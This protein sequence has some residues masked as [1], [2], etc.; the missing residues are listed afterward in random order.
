[1]NE[2]PDFC[3]SCPIRNVTEGYAPLTH[4]TGSELLVGEASGEEEVVQGRQFVGGAGSWL[5]SMLRAARLSRGKF[6]IINTI[7]CRPPK[8]C[9][10]TDENFE[11]TSRQYLVEKLAAER[12]I[13][14]HKQP[15]TRA[16]LEDEIAPRVPTRADGRAAVEYCARHH[17]LPVIDELEP[18]RIVAL[19]DHALR[20]LTPRQGVLT[21]RGSPLPLKGRIAEGLRV[22]GTLHPAYLMRNAGLF[23]VAVQDLRRSLTIAPEH[24]NLWP[25]LEDVRKFTATEFSFDFEWDDSGN[26][27]ICGLSDRYYHALVVPWMEPYLGELRRIFE[28]AT[29]FIGQNIIGA[30][31]QHFDRL[32]WNFQRLGWKIN[33]RVIDIMLIQHLVQPDMRHD[34]GFIGSVFANKVYW[35]G[36]GEE[37]EDE[38]G[39][40]AATG[41]QWK[42]WDS[43]DAIPREFG[44]YGGCAN[45]A[46]SFRLYNARDTEGSLQC[47]EPLLASLKKFGLEHT[48]WNVSV[49]AAH[50][51]RRMAEHG[52]RVNNAKVVDIRSTIVEQIEKIEKTLPEGLAPY[53]KAIIRQIEAP[54]DTYKPKSR[55][56]KGS[57]K[58][59]GRHEPREFVFTRPG[60]SVTC[61]ECSSELS[62]PKLQ[63]LKRIK[64]PGTER[65]TPWNSAEQVKKYAESLGCKPYLHSKT[66]RSTADKNAR[67]TWGREHVEFAAVDQLKKLGTQKNSFAKEELQNIDRVY[68]NLLVHGTSEGRLSSSGKRRGID[69]NIQNQPKSIRKIFVP[70]FDGWGILDSDVVQGENMITAWLAKDWDRWERLHSPGYDEH[71]DMASKFFNC[72]V[73]KDNEFAYLRAPGKVINHGRN[74]GLGVKKTV[75]YLAAQGFFYTQA[76]VS[77]MIEIWKR[78][79]RR[80]AQWQQETIEIAQRQGFLENA[81]GRRRWFQSRDYATKA[82]AFLPAST[83]ADIVLRCMIA[84]HPDEFPEEIAALKLQ[85][86]GR[87]PEPWF[88]NI[89]VHDSLVA[90]GPHEL[91][92]QAAQV[93]RT[94]MT[95]PWR[96]LD[97]FVLGVEQ[98]YSTESWGSVRKLEA[99]APPLPIAA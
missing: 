95:Q 82:L 28:N 55:A 16:A 25:T 88:L 41:A 47:V 94:V 33:V 6:H 10:P 99:E 49:P 19:G 52:L 86:T 13:K 27:T 57:K 90:Q 96:E 23:S 50:I 63:L 60:T 80:T 48:Y 77:E 8:N 84:L 53:E 39:N 44:G 2:R 59:G 58:S 73:T 45:G 83:L 93:I 68:F 30:D 89:Q 29:C 65:I 37:T 15:D 9:Y 31:M 69:P 98:A 7:G 56:C 26:I 74:Y 18:S 46:E 3:A 34:L 14:L 22:V 35:K 32:G 36:R 78:A 40:I 66:G 4:G 54:A 67:K 38:Q 79:N 5:N 87:L 71:S 42:T 72:N 64:V 12:G 97:N 85:V 62:A 24:Y 1:L 61:S 76:D 91:R 70:D 51:C 20:A 17:L 81:F 43:P 11:E 92:Q 75:E 21:W